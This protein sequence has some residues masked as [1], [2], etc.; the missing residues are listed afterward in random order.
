MARA[1]CCWVG[2]A[3]AL[4]ME[5]F[6]APRSPMVPASLRAAVHAGTRVMVLAKP[7]GVFVWSTASVKCNQGSQLGVSL[8]R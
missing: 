4:A 6:L 3:V 8:E 7:F 2:R 1:R 5:L